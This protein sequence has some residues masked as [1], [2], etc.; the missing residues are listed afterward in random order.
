MVPQQLAAELATQYFKQV[1]MSA[2]FIIIFLELYRANTLHPAYCFSICTIHEAC[3]VDDLYL[4]IVLARST[5]GAVDRRGQ[6][7]TM[8]VGLPND[9]KYNVA[10]FSMGS[11]CL[12]VA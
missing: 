6:L 8:L 10:S 12:G 5:V 7:F 4:H 1:S 2:P 11:L 9:S 3:A